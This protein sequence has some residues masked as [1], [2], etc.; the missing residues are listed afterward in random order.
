MTSL[1]ERLFSGGQQGWICPRCGRV[2]GPY[3]MECIHCNK[4]PY[5]TETSTD[6]PTPGIPAGITVT[7]NPDLTTTV[8]GSLSEIEKS[9]TTTTSQVP[10]QISQT[11]VDED[12][13]HDD[14]TSTQ[15]SAVDFLRRTFPRG[16]I[17]PRIIIKCKHCGAT[18][19]L[20][21]ECP[22]CGEFNGDKSSKSNTTYKLE[23]WICTRCGKIHVVFPESGCECGAPLEYLNYVV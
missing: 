20:N 10:D 22:I 19:Y 17:N 11:Q 4:E 7:Y 23:H 5:K 9:D 2:Y 16:G 8:T 15:E 13:H 6:I 12:S 18:A 1:H 14:N 21:K 3:V